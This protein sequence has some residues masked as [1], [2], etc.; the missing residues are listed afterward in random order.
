MQIVATNN[1]S[2]RACDRRYWNWL[3][4]DTICIRL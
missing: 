2:I 3:F 1:S 4:N